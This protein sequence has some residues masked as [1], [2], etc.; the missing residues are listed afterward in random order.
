[1]S[2][3]SIGEFNVPGH[4]SSV[5]TILTCPPVVAVPLS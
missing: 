5:A 1:L 3:R 2:L 4:A